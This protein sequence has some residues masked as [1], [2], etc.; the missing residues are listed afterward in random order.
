MKCSS[1]ERHRLNSLMKNIENIREYVC[2]LNCFSYAYI[3]R[4]GPGATTSGAKDHI[5]LI[6]NV[7]TMVLRFIVR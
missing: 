2:V 7:R 3:I 1:N 6:K 5:Y 4:H